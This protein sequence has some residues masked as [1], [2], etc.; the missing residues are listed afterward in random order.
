MKILKYLI[1]IFTLMVTT[2]YAVSVPKFADK[3]S[4]IPPDPIYKNTIL[5]PQGYILNVTLK[6]NLTCDEIS[7]SDNIEVLLS[8]DFTYKGKIIAEEGSMLI[9]KFVRKNI[10]NNVCKV[11]AKFTNIITINGANIPVSAVFVEENSTG[12][13]NA[14]NDGR[15]FE[16]NNA[17]I[18][19]KQ[20]VTYIPRN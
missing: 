18:I 1:L 7:P 13:I 10:D 11:R 8:D 15:L 6:K 5:I 2:V 14:L 19:I 12:F 17:D 4:N 16:D 3:K 20:P 9:G